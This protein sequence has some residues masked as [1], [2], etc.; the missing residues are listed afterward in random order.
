[1][2]SKLVKKIRAEKQATIQRGSRVNWRFKGM[3]EKLFVLTV[4]DVSTV[5][6]YAVPAITK[7]KARKIAEQLAAGRRVLAFYENR[8]AVIDAAAPM[9]CGEVR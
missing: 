9:P 4:K 3:V 6:T 1:M 7:R 2:N 5:K 8:N